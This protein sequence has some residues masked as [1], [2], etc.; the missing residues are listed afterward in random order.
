MSVGARVSRREAS[1][2]FGT[3]GVLLVTLDV[4]LRR[5]GHLSASELEALAAGR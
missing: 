1:M 5:A 2:L 4:E 3:L